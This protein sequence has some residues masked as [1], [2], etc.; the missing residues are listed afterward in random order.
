MNYFKHKRSTFHKTSYSYCNALPGKAL[1]EENV[2]NLKRHQTQ[3][4][5][6]HSHTQH[7]K[8]INCQTVYEYC[9]LR[10]LFYDFC[11][12]LDKDKKSQMKTDAC[13]NIE[14]INCFHCCRL[15]KTLFFRKQLII[16]NVLV[17][18]EPKQAIFK[19]FQGWIHGISW[20]RWVS[21]IF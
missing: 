17:L 14:S 20:T 21:I 6:S 9:I 12:F 10:W 2:S 1:N 7:F 4:F 19:D 15:W 16:L 18:A 3:T 13:T 11:R 8:E 5:L